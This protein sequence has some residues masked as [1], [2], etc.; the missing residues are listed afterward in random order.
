MKVVISGGTLVTEYG[1]FRGDLAVDEE[2]RIASI[3]AEGQALTRSKAGVTIDATGLYVLPGAVDGHSHLNDPGYTDSEDFYTGTCG[4]AAGG[5]TTVLEHPLTV[6]LPDN[7]DAFMA[8]KDIARAK[9]V[10][11]FGLWGALTPDNTADRGPKAAELAKMTEAGA[12]AFKGFLTY[13][14]EIPRL[15]DG[16]LLTAFRRIARLGTPVGLH[17][18]NAEIVRYLEGYL[19][20]SGR[21]DP[22][23]HGEARPELTEVEAVGRVLEL[24][25]G[26]GAQ[27]HLVHLSVPEAVDLVAQARSEGQFVSAET[28]HH[29]LSLTEEAL[30]KFGPYAK[31]NPP[32]RPSRCVEGLWERLSRG[33]IDSIGSDHGPFTREEKEKD[34]FWDVPAGLSGIQVMLPVVLSEAMRR[35]VPLETVVR[36][37]SANPARIFHLYPRKGAIAPGS[38]ADLVLVDLRRAWKVTAAELFSKDKWTPHEGWSLTAR[39]KRTLVRGETVY[40]DGPADAA[41]GDRIKVKPGF[42]RFQAPIRARAGS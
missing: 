9:A 30:T 31:C 10:V 28:C 15:D 16:L 40:E 33:T 34:S 25:R 38:D 3:S 6:P 18:E 11:D 2:G 8:K 21:N 7:L 41:G 42:G 36:L 4:A 23:V 19:K 37:M 20:A 39:V 26:T 27:V 32:L 24:S 14:W 1:T 12:V 35:G 22:L 17:S 5:V 29:Y 13:T